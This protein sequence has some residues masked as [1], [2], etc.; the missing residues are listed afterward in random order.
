MSTTVQPPAEQTVSLILEAEV[1][2]DLDTGRL[3]LVA[4]TD[5]HMSDLDEVSPARLRGLV[6]DA[7]KRLDEFERLANEHEARILS[8]LGVAA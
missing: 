8:R 3:T 7:R 2:T 5:H 4:S 6:A 1:T